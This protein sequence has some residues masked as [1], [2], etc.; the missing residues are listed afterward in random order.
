MVNSL[1]NY[2]ENLCENIAIVILIIKWV[3]NKTN[4]KRIDYV[5]INL[6]A[7]I[8]FAGMFF[9]MRFISTSR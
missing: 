1:S 7:I 4:K 5:T 9:L 2:L 3:I 6:N 8:F